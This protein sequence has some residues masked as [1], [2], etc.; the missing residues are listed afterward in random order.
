MNDVN[1]N[2]LKGI[3]DNWFLI[4]FLGSLVIGWTHMQSRVTVL[5]QTVS[6]L[7]VLATQ[8]EKDISRLDNEFGKSIVDIQANILFI[9]EQLTRLNK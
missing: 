8:S 5:E 4:I 3:K 1:L 2:F 9:K 7:Q 6:Q